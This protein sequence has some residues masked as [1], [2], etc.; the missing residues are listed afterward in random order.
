MNRI[1]LLFNFLMKSSFLRS[2]IL[3]KYIIKILIKHNI[4]VNVWIK[5]KYFNHLCHLCKSTSFL[6]K[7]VTFI[8]F[9]IF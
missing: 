3:E 9:G 7:K 5:K 8:L 4:F 6:V 2:F 1:I